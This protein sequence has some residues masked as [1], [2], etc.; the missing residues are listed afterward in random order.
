MSHWDSQNPTA[1]QPDS[2]LRDI[3]LRPTQ[4]QRVPWYRRHDWCSPIVALHAFVMILGLCV[5]LVSLLGFCTWIGAIAVCIIALTGPIYYK[6]RGPDGTL[7][8]WSRGNKVAAALILVIF[9]L[10]EAALIYWQLTSGQLLML[11][12]NVTRF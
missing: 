10:G 6:Q 9:V 5:P 1:P 8:T 7:R 4:Y 2:A 3:T 12:R 11:Q